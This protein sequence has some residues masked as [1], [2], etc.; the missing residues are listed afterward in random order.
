MSARTDEAVELFRQ[1]CACSQAILAV[2]G[3]AS[4]VDRETAMR[5]AAGFA[6]GMRMGKTCGA[7]TGAYM[8]LGLVMCGPQCSSRPGRQTVY[9]AVE[10]LTRRFIERH[11]SVE[12]KTLLGADISTEQGMQ[13]ANAEDLFE[14]VCPRM[15]RDAAEIL[16]EIISQHPKR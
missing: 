8:V 3:P 12:C 2:Y 15:V 14:T 5:I 13:K 4:G 9:D 11:G 16:E 10:G 7:V 6:G 1:G